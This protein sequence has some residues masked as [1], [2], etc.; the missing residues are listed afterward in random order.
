VN[1][2]LQL[3][4]DTVFFSIPNSYSVTIRFEYISA[5]NK[6]D[7]ILFSYPA[8]QSHLSEDISS[9]GWIYVC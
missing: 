4:I 7:T 2:I 6:P 5:S 1:A 9:G 8:F 3:S